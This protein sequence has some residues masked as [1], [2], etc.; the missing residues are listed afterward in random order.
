MCDMQIQ[1]FTLS[2]FHLVFVEMTDSFSFTAIR[3]VT[4]VEAFDHGKAKATPRRRVNHPSIQ[5]NYC[6]TQNRSQNR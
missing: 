5:I 3:I 6:L 2:S 4:T 1:D